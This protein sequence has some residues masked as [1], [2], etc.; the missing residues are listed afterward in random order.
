[1]NKV[2]FSGHTTKETELKTMANG[3]ALAKTA[4]AVNRRYKDSAGNKQEETMFMDLAFYGKSAETANKYIVKGKKILI[5]GRLALE[6][7][8]KD[9]KKHERYC[10]Y[11]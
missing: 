10:V 6:K 9:G 8:E 2:I 5:E 4:I 1:M 11:V 7:W 3:T